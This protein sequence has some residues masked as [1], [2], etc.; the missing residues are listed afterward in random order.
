[1]L[2]V[3]AAPSAVQAQPAGHIPRIG[4]LAVASS[5][6]VAARAEAFR[7]GLRDR[8]YMEGTNIV[9]EYRYADRSL[10]RLRE[11]AE[12]LARINVDVIVSGGPLAT[13]P[14]REATAT[15]PIVMGFDTDPVGAGFVA[16]LARPGGNVPGC[17]PSPRR[18]AES[19]WSCERI[20]PR[21]S[22][23]AVLGTSTEPAQPQMLRELRR[24]AE[25]FKI[26]LQ[27][28]EVRDP[29]NSTLHSRVRERGVPRP[30]SC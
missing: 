19:S 25:V 8:G 4:F 30:P 13:R 23:V 3:L 22:R 14:A 2:G 12:E 29:G 27:Y 17:P 10:S 1:M 20:R 11:L 9:I 24:A 18:L 6:A 7:Q 21:L 28:L 26:Q 16:S 15:I 5:Q